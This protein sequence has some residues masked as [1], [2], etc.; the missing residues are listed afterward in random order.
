MSDRQERN[1]QT[2]LTS[3]NYVQPVPAR[4]RHQEVRRR[5]LHPALPR[6]GRWQQAFIDYFVRMAKNYRSI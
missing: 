2:A 4:R 5:Q 3:T 1:K 6:G